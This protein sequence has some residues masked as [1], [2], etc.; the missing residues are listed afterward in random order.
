MYT[1]TRS[2]TFATKNF[3]V[4]LFSDVSPCSYERL[5]II[6]SLAINDCFLNV[7]RHS[8]ALQQSTSAVPIWSIFTRANIHQLTSCPFEGID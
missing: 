1:T 7:I 8:S 4:S 2:L 5:P 6:S 3:A